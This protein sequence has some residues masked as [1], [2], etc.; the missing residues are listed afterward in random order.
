MVDISSAVAGKPDRRS[1]LKLLG[2]GGAVGLAGCTGGGGDGEETTTTSGGG[3]TTTAGEG[4]GEEE[5][6]EATG[7]VTPGGHLRVAGISKPTSLDPFKGTGKGDYVFQEFM[8]DRL[9]DYNRDME[10]VPNLAKEWEPNEEGS[11]WTF[12]L[13]EGVKFTTLDQEVLAEDVKATVDVMLSED[14]AAGAGSALGPI[15][16]ETPVVVEDDYRVTINLTKPYP[17]YPG[18][19]AETGSHFNIIPKNVAESRFGELAEKD[20]GSG[21]FTLEDYQTDNYYAF[22]AN[23]DW[24]RTDENGNQLPYVDKLTAKITPDPVGRINALTGERVDSIN[25][26]PVSF[27]KQI[28]ASQKASNHMF[29]TS[30]FPN[31]VLNTTLELENGDK[32]FA[33]VRVRKAMKHALDREQIVAATN[34]TMTIGHHDPVA[35]VHPDYAPFDEGLEFGTT[36]QPDKAR[37]LLEEA[38]YGDG[39]TLPTPIYSNEYIQRKGTCMKLFQQQMKKVGIEFDIRKV[40]PDTWL[41]EHWNREN[42]WYLSNWAARINQTS[43]ARKTLGPESPWDSGKW[44]NEEYHK[45]F[46]TFTETV[47][48]EEFKEAFHEAQRISH[49]NNAW[50][51]FGFFKLNAAAND[52]VDPFQ[53]GPSFNRDQYFDAGLTSEAPEG[54]SE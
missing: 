17:S 41:T 52:Y 51:V 47:D 37:A 34:G 6:T 5:T 24:F 39:L 20:F 4:G 13:H 25:S 23:K 7:G 2:V 43:V 12:D 14:K 48:D 45:Q 15:D 36:A 30:N 27:R 18:R 26:I 8:Y 10:V 9:T 50:I 44:D 49:L 53:A 19:I 54:P 1:Y 16:K 31:M 32:P 42:T 33:D 11:V 46:N 28:E 29:T 40:S 35:P 21:P 3:E 22:K 38:G